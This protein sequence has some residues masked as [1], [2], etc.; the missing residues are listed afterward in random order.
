[1]FSTVEGYT[2]R[3]LWMET[4]SSVGYSAVLMIFPRVVNTWKDV[5]KK[6]AVIQKTVKSF[7]LIVFELSLKKLVSGEYFSTRSYNDARIYKNKFRCTS[8]SASESEGSKLF[9]LCGLILY[10]DWSVERGILTLKRNY[11][12]QCWEKPR[13]ET[14]FPFFRVYCSQSH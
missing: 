6:P 2:Q 11:Q 4:T 7:Q 5:S 10:G 9:L 13:K 12:C 8:D 14:K 1:M 3:L